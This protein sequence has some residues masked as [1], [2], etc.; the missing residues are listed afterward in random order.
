MGIARVPLSNQQHWFW[1]YGRL[2][3][4]YSGSQFDVKSAYRTSSAPGTTFLVN[5]YIVKAVGIGSS[6]LTKKVETKGRQNIRTGETSNHFTREHNPSSVS[7]CRT[8]G[9][10]PSIAYCCLIGIKAERGLMCGLESTNSLTG[11]LAAQA[12]PRSS[13]F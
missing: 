3:G 5:P 12:M 7:N 8:K 10:N 1:A 4:S 2:L 9:A 11:C 13:I 6:T